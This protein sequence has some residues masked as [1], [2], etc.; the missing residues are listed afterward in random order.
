MRKITLVSI[1]LVVSSF[2]IL[3][4][5]TRNTE[6]LL[7]IERRSFSGLAVG[8]SE[9]AIRAKFKG[10]LTDSTWPDESQSKA[11]NIELPCGSKAIVEMLEGSAARILVKRV[12]IAKL[13]KYSIE[14]GASFKDAERKFPTANIHY[15]LDEGAYVTLTL[16]DGHVVFIFDVTQ[17]AVELA[18]SSPKDARKI[19]EHSI[20]SDFYI[21]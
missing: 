15:G 8:M 16:Q 7:D 20:L 19:F 2:N 14:I 9:Q 3:S 18:K 6:C 12:A 10:R 5:D 17:S 11:L 21:K 4:A 13:S 1:L